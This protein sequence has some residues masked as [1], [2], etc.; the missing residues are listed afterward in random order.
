VYSV[1]AYGSVAGDSHESDFKSQGLRQQI[2]QRLGNV[3]LDDSKTNSQMEE[4]EAEEYGDQNP[5]M[6]TD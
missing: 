6:V 3:Q 2:I 4:E 1:G 5:M